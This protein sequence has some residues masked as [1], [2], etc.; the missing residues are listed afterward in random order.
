MTEAQWFFQFDE[1]KDTFKWFIEDY[2]EPSIW[3]KI[4]ELRAQENKSQML[5][6]MNDIWYYLPDYRFNIN[7]N[8]KGWTEFLNLIEE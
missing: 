2:F 3:D 6:L 5:L 4:L 8:P 1:T 7:V